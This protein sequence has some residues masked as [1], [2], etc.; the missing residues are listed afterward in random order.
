MNANELAEIESLKQSK[1][2]PNNKVNS[3]PVAWM[4]ERPNGSAKLVYVREPCDNTV[5]KEVP[6]YTHP[7]KEL[8]DEEIIAEAQ[9]VKYSELSIAVND[10]YILFARAIL[11]KAQEK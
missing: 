5:V 8:T 9:G 1:F 10:F 3:E 2:E 6:L 4:Y 11:R 7:V